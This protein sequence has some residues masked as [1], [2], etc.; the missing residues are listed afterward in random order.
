MT[1]CELTELV[2][3]T[4]VMGVSNLYGKKQTHELIKYTRLSNETTSSPETRKGGA[5]QEWT[6][7]HTDPLTRSLLSGPG[8]SSQ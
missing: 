8:K 4:W 5:P 7:W 1:T 2:R 6:W 3:S